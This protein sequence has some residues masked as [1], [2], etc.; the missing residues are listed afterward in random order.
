MTSLFPL[1]PS[2]SNELDFLSRSLFRIIAYATWCVL[3]ND[4]KVNERLEKRGNDKTQNKTQNYY[5]R[6][7]QILIKKLTSLC[8]RKIVKTT[9][10]CPSELLSKASTDIFE[11]TVMQFSVLNDK[12]FHEVQDIFSSSTL[13]WR[14]CSPFYSRGCLREVRLF[15]SSDDWSQSQRFFFR[16]LRLKLVQNCFCRF[17]LVFLYSGHRVL[18]IFYEVHPYL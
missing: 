5:A 7:L 14:H 17:N 18:S 12:V 15:L 3:L 10:P 9:N 2:S 16:Y 4:E 11:Q 1:F 8:E 6:E 13:R